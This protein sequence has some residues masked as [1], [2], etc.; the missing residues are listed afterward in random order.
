[1]ISEGIID[2]VVSIFDT[3]TLFLGLITKKVPDVAAKEN[4][5]FLR[6]Y[7]GN[8]RTLP[9][10]W[11]AFP[12]SIRSPLVIRYRTRVCA[13]GLI[14]KSEAITAPRPLRFLMRTSTQETCFASLDSMA[15][16]R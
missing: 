9:P 5:E 14:Y 10:L 4:A 2:E 11:R 15:W 12:L 3:V 8:G 1:M 16:I 13:Q 7:A 6:D